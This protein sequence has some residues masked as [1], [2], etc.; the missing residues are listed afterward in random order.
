[1]RLFKILL[2]KKSIYL[3]IFVLLALCILIPLKPL[4]NLNDQSVAWDVISCFAN[5][6]EIDNL[7]V[8]TSPSINVNLRSTP[9]S[10][11]GPGNIIKSLPINTQVELLYNVYIYSVDQNNAWF[12][13]ETKNGDSG[14]IKYNASNSVLLY[15]NGKPLD[16]EK[17]VTSFQANNCPST[18]STTKS[19][20]SSGGGGNAD[21]PIVADNCCNNSGYTR[22]KSG[23][24]NDKWV[25][26]YWDKKDNNKCDDTTMLDSSN[27]GGGGGGNCSGANNC[28]VTCPDGTSYSDSCPADGAFSSCSQWETEACLNHQRSNSNSNSNRTTTNECSNVSIGFWIK[29]KS[30]Y[31]L[32]GSAMQSNAP[33]EPFKLDINC[34]ADTGNSLLGN[35]RLQLI[36]DGREVTKQGNQIMDWEISTRGTYQA[37]CYSSSGRSCANSTFTINELNVSPAEEDNGSESEEEAIVAQP[38]GS[39]CKADILSISDTTFWTKNNMTE[40]ITYENID[41]LNSSCVSNRCLGCID[42]TKSVWTCAPS[43]VDRQSYCTLFDGVTGT[44]YTSSINRVK[45][46]YGDIT[47]SVSKKIGLLETE[48]GFLC[49]PIDSDFNN[50]IE[51]LDF[52]DFSKAYKYFLEDKRLSCSNK[53]KDEFVCG[54]KDVNEDSIVDFKDFVDFAGRYLKEDCRAS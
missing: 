43:S 16:D 29:D 50:K 40:Y 7:D 2:N 35:S 34:F 39:Y 46:L 20:S 54:T 27:N 6:K 47:T 23:S 38:I 42:G 30:S 5:G 32:E 9:V 49:G 28:S 24:D 10:S 4:N 14:Y 51:F 33:K 21:Y 31:W 37:V 13:V 1:M 52:I 44:N 41:N 3:Q 25:K 18:A 19:S 48:D 36:K 26:G 15:A 8:K 12:V 22:C 11:T 45:S 17:K 53:Y